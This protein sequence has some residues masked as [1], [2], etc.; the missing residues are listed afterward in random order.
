REPALNAWTAERIALAS[1]DMEIVVTIPHDALPSTMRS[2]LAALRSQKL[3]ATH[4][5]KNWGD[6]IHL[7]NCKT[8][9]SIEVVRGLTST[10][11]IEVAEEETEDILPAIQRAFHKLGWVGR[12]EEGEYSLL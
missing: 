6:W 11:T 2:V 9:I 7:K 1:A 5:A 12:D 4:S 8:V 3:T 10:A